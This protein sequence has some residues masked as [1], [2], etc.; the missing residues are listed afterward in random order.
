MGTG[1]FILGWIEKSRKSRNPGDR[2][3]DLKIPK[4]AREK[5]PENPGVAIGILKNRKNPKKNLEKILSA[6]FQKS[7][8]PGD[9]DRDRDLKISKKSRKNLEWKIRRNGEF[10]GI[11][12][13]L[14]LGI[15]IPRIRDFS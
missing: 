5:N 15:L 3:R 8:N 9:R 13:S 1:F 11:R 14:S 12:D 7:L 4:K 10:P 2:D 6:K